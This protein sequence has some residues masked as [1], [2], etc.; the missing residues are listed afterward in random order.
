M[1]FNLFAGKVPAIGALAFLMVGVFVGR[2][3]VHT[4]PLRVAIA[5]R[6]ALV[7]E[8]SLAL[9]L[10]DPAALKAQVSDPILD[11]IRRYA[12]TGFVVID[13]VQDDQG[14]Y[15]VLAL[16]EDAV[17]ITAEMKVALD[18]AAPVAQAAAASSPV[19]VRQ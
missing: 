6:S 13:A 7:F 5:E 3:S 8:R 4:P 11:V 19:E 2:Q 10:R 1:K 17:D 14:Y 15:S 12:D 18:R 9:G 16:P